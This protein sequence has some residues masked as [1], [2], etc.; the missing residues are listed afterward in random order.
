MSDLIEE[1]GVLQEAVMGE[2]KSHVPELLEKRGWNTKTFVAHCM[3]A[4][5]GQETAYRLARGDVNVNI[6]TVKV[7]AKVLGVE[8]ISEVIDLEAD[9]EQ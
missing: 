5:L 2:L 4:G 9:S 3:L 6:E 8:S 1:V 7:A